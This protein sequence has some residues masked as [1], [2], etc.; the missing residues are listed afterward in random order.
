MKKIVRLITS[1]MLALTLLGLTPAVFAATTTTDSSTDSSQSSSTA[2]SES[3]T[4]ETKTT[5]AQ[6]VENYKT[7][8][9]IKLTVLE[10]NRLKLRCKAGQVI[11]KTLSTKIAQNDT[12]RVKVYGEIT[13][14]LKKIT[15]RLE[16]ANVDTTDLSAEQTKLADLIKTYNTDATNYKNVLADLG[17]VDCVADPVAYKA[18]L[19]S[20]RTDRAT[21][22]KDALAIR[23]Y[24][25]DTIKTTL[26]IAQTSLADTEKGAQ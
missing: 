23:A 12:A 13:T 3:T 2:A 15:A 7:K 19:E 21:V 25:T 14:N 18:V 10:Q 20:A 17:D 22:S 4:K 26:K 5:L 9:A 11:T 6:R 1:G 16:D 24:I 8:Q